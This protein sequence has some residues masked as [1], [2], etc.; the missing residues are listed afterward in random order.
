MTKKRAAFGFTLIELL[1]SVAIVATLAVGATSLIENSVR[2]AKEFELRS[3]LRQIRE[4][5][6]AYKRASDNGSVAHSIDSSGYPPNLEILVSGVADAKSPLRRK[7]Y[8]LRR[9]PSDP[10]AD[11]ESGNQG[12]GLRSYASDPDD[13]QPGRDV[14]DVYSTSPKVGLNGVPYS[15]W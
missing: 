8:F 2:R 5:I 1:I 14:F 13:P 11:A 9:L 7:I 12:W 15:K 10:M 4:A 3:D 6:D